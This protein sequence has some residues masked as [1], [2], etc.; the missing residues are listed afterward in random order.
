MKFH[1]LGTILFFFIN[2]EF[3]TGKGDNLLTALSVARDCEIIDDDKE[4]ILVIEARNGKDTR[5][6]FAQKNEGLT[7]KVNDQSK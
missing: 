6:L 2:L 3:S 5:F 7:N 4:Q 1:F